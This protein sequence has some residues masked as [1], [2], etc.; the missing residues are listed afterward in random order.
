MSQVK[1][2]FLSVNGFIEQQLQCH[3]SYHTKTVRMICIE[4]DEGI[5]N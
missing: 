2:S 3:H 1:D 4:L 5:C